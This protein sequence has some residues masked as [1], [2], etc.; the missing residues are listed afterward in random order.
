MCGIF[1]LFH[2]ESL[3]APAGGLLRRMAHALRH[4][5]PDGEGF[6]VEPGVALGHR[7]LAIVDIAGGQQPMATPD[8]RHVVSFNG[9]IFNHVTLR[10]DL[11]GEGHVFRTRSDTEVLLHGWRE[12]GTGLVDRLNGQ[13]AFAL[14]DGARAEL[15]LARDRLGEKPLHYARLPDRTIA[16]ASEPGALLALPGLSRMLDREAL[17]DYLAL[18]Y[19]PDPGTIHA[20]IR[21]VPP[22]HSL[23]L[24]RDMIGLPPPRRYWQP[25]T[26][27]PPPPPSRR[28]SWPGAWRRRCGCA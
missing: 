25:P 14:W 19:V 1:G 12:W 4:R 17:D 28:R 22:A 23:T 10:R 5:G 18:G 2:P 20:A 16:F 13:F 27:S 6:H 21:Q 24:R 15:L 26:R 8:G 11:E 3:R 9:E 7:R